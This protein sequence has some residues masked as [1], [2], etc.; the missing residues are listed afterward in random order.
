MDEHHGAAITEL[1]D[2]IEFANVSLWQRDGFG[3]T[4]CST[5]YSLYSSPGGNNW[6]LA[7]NTGFYRQFYRAIRPGMVRWQATSSVPNDRVVAFGGAGKGGGGGAVGRRRH[8]GCPG[9]SRGIL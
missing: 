1:F 4:G 2:A 9:P 6:F 3:G 5:C 7:G 8:R